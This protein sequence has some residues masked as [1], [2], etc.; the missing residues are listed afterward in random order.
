MVTTLLQIN[1]MY[2]KG[3]ID[4]SMSYE[5]YRNL[6]DNLLLENKTTGND[7][8]AAMINYTNMNVH[9]MKRL[10]K[11]TSMTEKGIEELNTLKQSYTWL[12]LTEA[13][14]GD[15]AQTVPVMN[16]IAESSNGK[17]SVRFILRD[18]HLDIIDAHLT[19]NGRA[20]PKLIV[21]DNSLKEVTNWGPRPKTLQDMVNVWKADPLLTH[22]DWSEKVHAWYAKDKTQQTMLELL[23]LIGE[24]NQQ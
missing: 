10:D 20:I 15:A 14:C 7:Q 13:W 8:A 17:I 6:I 5:Q 22:E 12:V 16:K 2:S 4:S 9:R 11:T 19:K 3:L 24:I 18:E 1:M 21:L 23:D